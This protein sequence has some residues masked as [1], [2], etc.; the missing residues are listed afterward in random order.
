MIAS[1]TN[2]RP[3]GRPG[4]SLPEPTSFRI[5]TASTSRWTIVVLLAV[6]IVSGIA[7]LQPTVAILL[8]G[9]TVL[10]LLLY[11]AGPDASL[12]WL[13]L[14]PWQ[15][16]PGVS[17]NILYNP[18]LWAGIVRLIWAAQKSPHRSPS[19]VIGVITLPM[20]YVFYSV[21]FGVESYSLLYWTLPT[22]VLSASFYVKGIDIDRVGAALYKVGIVCSTLTLLEFVSS[23]S[24]NA[25]LASSSQVAQYLASDRALGP[26][27][28]PLFTSS[29]LIVSFF[30]VPP[31]KRSSPWMQA[32]IVVAILVTGSKS[33]VIALLA[34]VVFSLYQYGLKRMLGLVASLGLLM[35]GALYFRPK[36]VEA[37][38]ARFSVFGRLNDFD[39]DRAFT[40]DFVL[41]RIYE[42]PF[43]GV[44]VG[45]VLEDKMRGSPV[46]GG[47]QY[48][49]ESTWLAMA[50][51]IGLI[52]IV[53]VF[54]C[55]C[56]TVVRAF[57]VRSSPALLALVI[58]LF[59]WNGFFG[60]WVIAPL[61]V[62]LLAFSDGCRRRQTMTHYTGL[63]EH[64]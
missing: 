56:L 41:G 27:G 59:F 5:R 55:L 8:I 21:V 60:A 58:S 20:A 37:A 38:F 42:H 53:L 36:S 40:L 12:V 43:G 45:S 64:A 61:W 26:T 2:P 17:A 11:R 35:T 28:N 29:I 49:I 16:L 1:W 54:L 4:P 46:E 14:L 15:F 52:P 47:S 50:A 19:F 23:M 3:I 44:P 31:H 18:W 62:I 6:C 30:F 7:A 63:R 39:P 22:L 32:L 33:A 57:G 34:G 9:L 10:A 25:I 24:L 48:G 51:D 13:L